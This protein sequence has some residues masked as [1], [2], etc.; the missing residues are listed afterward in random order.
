MT[1]KSMIRTVILFYMFLTTISIFFIFKIGDYALFD[2]F[3]LKIVGF[4][5]IT[6]IILE[7]LRGPLFV[8][9]APYVR[10]RAFLM[11]GAGIYVTSTIY[12]YV[13]FICLLVSIGFDINKLTVLSQT[14]FMLKNIFVS[15][16]LTMFIY[17]FIHRRCIL[18]YTLVWIGRINSRFVAEDYATQF[19]IIT[20]EET[21]YKNRAIQFFTSLGTLLGIGYGWFY[22]GEKDSIFD[23]FNSTTSM[24]TFVFS[25]G[26]L[27]YNSISSLF[28]NDDLY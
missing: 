2:P 20:N 12:I 28:H 11:V 10:I 9:T 24:L 17:E 5:S 3:N 23:V 21:N 14:D 1:T 26:I 13:M 7:V 6:A 25:I 16:L 15:W 18:R 8:A 4:L 19:A 22:I 27:V